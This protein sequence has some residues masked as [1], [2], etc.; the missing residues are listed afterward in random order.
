MGDELHCVRL[1]R[2][3]VDEEKTNGNVKSPPSGDLECTKGYPIKK[4]IYT[5]SATKFG[6]GESLEKKLKL[7]RGCTKDNLDH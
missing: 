6:T 7:S 5:V 1:K 2:K 4:R 3:A